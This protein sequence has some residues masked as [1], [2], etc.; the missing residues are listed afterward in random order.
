LQAVNSPLLSES[1]LQAPKPCDPKLLDRLLQF[2]GFPMPYLKQD[3]R[4]S[5]RWQKLRYQQLFREDIRDAT[6]VID[7]QK[8]ETLA[9][10]LAL[11]PGSLTTYSNLA[12]KVKVSVDTITRWIQIL[13]SFYFCYSIR[14]WSKN[15]ARSLLKEPKIF[16]WDWSSIK[17]PGQKA[18]NLIASHL[19]KAVHYWSDV[20]FG[21][22]GL[23]YLRTIDKREVDFLVT[24]NEEPWFLVEVK[25]GD[26]SAIGK[27]LYYF[28]EQTGAKH[29]FQ[30][31]LEKP[32]IDKDC[33]S[34]TTPII[35]PAMTLLS[36][37]V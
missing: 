9:N 23:Y 33:F 27:N 20:G 21:D 32:Y 8:L 5:T 19:L 7:L 3:P 28:L 22:Y 10:I 18:E 24:K 6:S 36:Q 11:Q 37:L 4:F 35:V 16:L 31:S 12:N 26:P 15:I 30:V 34:Y 14:P 1:E 17:D 13:E 29:A 2:G 25:K